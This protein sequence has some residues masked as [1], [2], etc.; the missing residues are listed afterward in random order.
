MGSSLNTKQSVIFECWFSQT[1]K[2]NKNCSTT[3]HCLVEFSPFDTTV[4]YILKHSILLRDN[5]SRSYCIPPRHL[6]RFTVP[7]ETSGGKGKT[8]SARNTFDF[9]A[10][11]FKKK[12]K[13]K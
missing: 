13:K 7:F 2:T 5:I 11:Q 4:T 6:H 12:K 8:I 10:N 9:S 1:K 3:E